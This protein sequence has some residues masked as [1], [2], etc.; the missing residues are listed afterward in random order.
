MYDALFAGYHLI[1]Y[2]GYLKRFMLD[3]S[4]IVCLKIIMELCIN[5]LLNSVQK[6]GCCPMMNLSMN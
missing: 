2:E 3:Y 6:I 1:V 4:K 5:F